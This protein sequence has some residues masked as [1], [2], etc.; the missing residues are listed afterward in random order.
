MDFLRT[1]KPTSNNNNS[2]NELNKALIQVNGRSAY[3]GI[4]ESLKE[5]TSP[6][7][8]NSSAIEIDLIKEIF[9]Y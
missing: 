6:S 8:V 2:S 1:I 4:N 5:H 3:V 7:Y 9:S